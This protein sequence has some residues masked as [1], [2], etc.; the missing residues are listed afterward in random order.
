[1][2]FSKNI[3]KK[4]ASIK[5]TKY[6]DRPLNFFIPISNPLSQRFI[7]LFYQ[8]FTIKSILFIKNVRLEHTENLLLPKIL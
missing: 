5:L 2:K 8:K 6:T 1:M 7:G 3:R 4:A